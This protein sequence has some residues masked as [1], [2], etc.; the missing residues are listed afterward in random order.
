MK[1]QGL[2]VE[3]KGDVEAA[4][5]NWEMVERLENESNGDD[6]EPSA[7]SE[8]IKETLDDDVQKLQEELLTLK[9]LFIAAVKSNG[10]KLEIKDRDLVNS[11]PDDKLT[12]Y[13]DCKNRQVVF[14]TS[15][16]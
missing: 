3:L 6:R 7:K 10:G 12:R 2:P 8:I 9:I 1:I 11:M 4:S 13:N 14:S 15:N 5:A 16:D